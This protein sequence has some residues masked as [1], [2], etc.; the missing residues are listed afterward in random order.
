MKYIILFMVSILPATLTACDI[1]GCGAGNSYIGIL[2]DFQKHIMGLRYRT[3][4]MLT[5]VGA[6]GAAT[7][8]TTEEHYHTLEAWAGWNINNKFRLMAS[9]PYSFN[10]KINQGIVQQKNGPGD[11]NLAGYYQLINTR[12]AISGNHLLVQSLWLG[13]GVKIASGIYN[14]AD[15]LTDEQSTNLFQLGTG[16]F[17]FTVNTMYDIRLQDFGINLNAGYKINT[18]NKYGYQ[19]GNKVSSSAQVYYKHRVQNKVTISP[20]V[21]TLLEISGKDIDRGLS[22]NATGGR[23]LMGT[24]GAEISF[25]KLAVGGNFQTPISQTLAAGIVH[26]GNRVMV[27]VAIVL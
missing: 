12:K 26:A 24:I 3:N 19:Y 18:S 2:P 5:H 6:G 17:D 13:A 4:S 8:L 14:P 22:V 7:Y 15:K 1:C 25:A 27:H 20:G 11:I 21:G 9:I 10:E 16:S 23:I